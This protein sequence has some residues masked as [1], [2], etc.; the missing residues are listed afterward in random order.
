MGACPGS[1]GRARGH[2]TCPYIR[3]AG[4]GAEEGHMTM[5]TEVRAT[6]PWAQG[7]GKLP[8]AGQGWEILPLEPSALPART[9]DL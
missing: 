1:C 7:C 9:C 6:R 3:E 5:E 8:E 4:V 2:H